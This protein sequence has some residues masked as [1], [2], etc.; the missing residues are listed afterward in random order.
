MK[1]LYQELGW[2]KVFRCPPPENPMNIVS[3]ALTKM[4]YRN[5]VNYTGPI[6]HKLLAHF[7]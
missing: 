3:F 1:V 5:W 4:H 7:S 6:P 2:L